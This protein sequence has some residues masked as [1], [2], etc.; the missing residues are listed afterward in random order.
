MNSMK[1][2][3]PQHFIS[4]KKDSKPCCDMTTPESIHTF[5]W[6][7]S[8]GY[9][10]F[11]VDRILQPYSCVWIPWNLSCRNILFHERK[12][13]NHAVTWRHSSQ[14]TPKMKVNGSVGYLLMVVDCRQNLAVT[15]KV[16]AINHHYILTIMASQIAR[17]G[18]PCVGGIVPTK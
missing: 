15:V 4:W 7:L 9:L 1:L 13:P 16:V 12:T 14:F 2:V 5:L 17:A 3:M 8:I 11:A 18:G 10:L 6:F